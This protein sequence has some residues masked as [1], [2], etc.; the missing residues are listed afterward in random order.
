M[1]NVGGLRF[2]L[3][4]TQEPLSDHEISNACA[5]YSRKQMGIF[6]LDLRALFTCEMSLVSRIL[7]IIIL[8]EHGIKI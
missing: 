5:H 7:K 1:L 4:G 8:R 2:P 6:R 3:T